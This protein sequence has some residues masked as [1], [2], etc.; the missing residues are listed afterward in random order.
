MAAEAAA[1]PKAE[2]TEPLNIIYYGN[3]HTACFPLATMKPREAGS[4]WI[5][6]Q[7]AQGAGQARTPAP[8]VGNGV[9]AGGMC[10][11]V[12][13]VK[14][15]Q[16]QTYTDL[17]ALDAGH[18]LAQA[19]FT[20][21]KDAKKGDEMINPLTGVV[22]EFHPAKN[23]RYTGHFVTIPHAIL[24]L[25]LMRIPGRG[26]VSGRDASCKKECR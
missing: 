10:R 2:N 20:I 24:V 22:V 14:K 23:N 16:G 4:Q 15:N 13:A 21:P 11:N 26:A 1:A 9:G 17:R 6:R 7:L 8:G 19:Q 25:V 18:T 5:V 3:S 12:L